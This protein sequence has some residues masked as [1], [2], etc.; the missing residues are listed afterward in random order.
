MSCRQLRL[1][2]LAPEGLKRLACGREAS[3]V[4]LYDLCFLAREVG[5]N[6]RSAHSVR[7]DSRVLT[8]VTGPSPTFMADAANGRTEPILPNAART[9]NWRQCVTR[10]FAFVAASAAEGSLF[11]PTTDPGFHLRYRDCQNDR[12]RPGS[13]HI[14]MNSSSRGRPHRAGTCLFGRGVSRDLPF[15]RRP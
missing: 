1:A 2:Y 15:P 3:A 5:A 6:K 14:S 12:L 8:G 13:P 7:G 4:S 10:T 11:R 9:A